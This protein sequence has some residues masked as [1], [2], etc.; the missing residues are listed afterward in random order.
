MSQILTEFFVSGFTVIVPTLVEKLN[1]P[2]ESV[3]WPAAAF[4]LVVASSL[5]VFGRLGDM[6][7]GFIVYL[8]GFIWLTVWSVI[9]GFSRNPLMLD[10]CRALQGVG[11]AAFLPAGIMLLGSVYRPGP[12]KNLA[13]SIYGACAVVGFY[14][15]I[16]FAGLTGQFIHWGWYFWIGAAL[17][18]ITVV[19]SYFFIPNDFHEKRKNGI[20][21][22]WYGSAFITSGLVLVVYAITDSMHS[23]QGWKTPYIPVTLV[24]GFALLG[25]AVY[26]EGWVAKLPLL[27]AE[28]FKVPHMSPLVVALVFSYGTLGIWMFYAVLYFENCMGASPIQVVAW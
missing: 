26:V 5:L 16:F 19:T 22:D 6:L 12:R 9:A 2:Q 4:S 17:S 13:F 11:P 23:P 7:G 14:V 15:G 8:F 20:S 24:L 28:V 1:I 25:V 21:M 3:V 27:P 18:A 10:F